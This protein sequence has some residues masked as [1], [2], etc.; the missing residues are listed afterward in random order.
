MLHF[1]TPGA[2]DFGLTRKLVS[3]LCKQRAQRHG[4]A[5]DLTCRPPCHGR[6]ELCMQPWY[7]CRA[8]GHSAGPWLMRR[9]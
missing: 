1:A 4:G 7:L 3:M 2:S 8:T 6:D 9:A 5:D